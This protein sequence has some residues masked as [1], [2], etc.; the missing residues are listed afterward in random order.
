MQKAKTVEPALDLQR[1]TNKQQILQALVNLEQSL[2]VT[3]QQAEQVL[4]TIIKIMIRFIQSCDKI[5]EN[6]FGVA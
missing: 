4:L 6:S 5:I 1:C 3:A 2:P